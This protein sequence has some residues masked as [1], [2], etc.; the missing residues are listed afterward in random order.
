VAQLVQTDLLAVFHAL[1]EIYVL[2]DRK[3]L[4]TNAFTLCTRRFVL[5]TTAVTFGTLFSDAIVA[6]NGSLSAT[7]EAD[8]WFFRHVS[9]S[10]FT[11][12]ADYS[13]VERYFRVAPVDGI[14]ETDF[15]V[16]FVICSTGVIS[17][18]IVFVGVAKLEEIIEF[19]KDF[20]FIFSFGLLIRF[21]IFFACL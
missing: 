17:G 1:W 20:F 14:Y 19:C 5:A 4:N 10:A 12:E 18:S 15:E 8:S 3:P 9:S 16:G 7:F 2:S 11:S 6:D 21:L 13:F